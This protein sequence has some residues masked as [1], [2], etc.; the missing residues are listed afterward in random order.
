MVSGG[1]ECITLIMHFISIIII[2]PSNHQA[3]DPREFGDPWSMALS[4]VGIE[5]S[6]E[7]LC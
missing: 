1:F 3:L 5:C 6:L 4:S 2:S 7:F